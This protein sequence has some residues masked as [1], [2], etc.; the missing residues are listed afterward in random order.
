MQKMNRVQNLS[1]C[2][3]VSYVV[4]FP[5]SCYDKT[6][7]TGKDKLPQ[8]ALKHDC[9][10][11]C[12]VCFVALRPKSTVM[13]MTGRSVYLTTLFPRQARTSS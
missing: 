1:N 10:G 4:P 3:R 13:A 8:N 7:T 12:I 11:K 6:N 5:Y 9:D 2:A